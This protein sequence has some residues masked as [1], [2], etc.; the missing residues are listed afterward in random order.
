MNIQICTALY[1]SFIY[2]YSLN[3][4]SARGPTTTRWFRSNKAWG[5]QL[6]QAAGG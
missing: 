5:L 1:Y 4:V 3:C 2:F 6:P